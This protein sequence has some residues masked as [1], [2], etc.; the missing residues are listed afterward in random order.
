MRKTTM[1]YRVVVAL[2]CIA[3]AQSARAQAADSAQHPTRETIG[4][5]LERST[6]G[7]PIGGNFKREVL[8]DARINAHFPIH[9]RECANRKVTLFVYCGLVGTM[10]VDVR[11]STDSSSPVR[12]PGYKPELR[13]YTRL[14]K[15]GPNTYGIFSIY[16]YSNGQE[17]PQIID[18]TVNLGYGSFNQT[19]NL[20]FEVA[21]VLTDFQ[22]A[23]VR[24]GTSRL[25][26]DYF[27]DPDSLNK[28]DYGRYRVRWI[29]TGSVATPVVESF[30]FLS[31]SAWPDGAHR[32][33]AI[34]HLDFDARVAWR[35]PIGGK[36]GN[37]G[38]Y[39]G[40][41]WGRDYL[42]MAYQRGNLSVVHIGLMG[43]N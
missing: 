8:F 12:S 21:S 6:I 5:L 34:E 10:G 19:I 16:H 4:A 36:F 11:M 29:G 9:I 26:V 42:T 28:A 18:D 30:V 3:F 35:F 40:F 24:L 33:S 39:V 15:M 38:P 23:K 41:Y 14:P 17:G 20:G 2:L 37:L 32:E 13:L 25:G 43:V 27:A 1:R 31:V 22:L 7:V